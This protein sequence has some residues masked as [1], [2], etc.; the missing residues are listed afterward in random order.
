MV[1][2]GLL[3]S[4][5]SRSTYPINL[6]LLRCCTYVIDKTGIKSILFASCG[7]L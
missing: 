7:N 1:N 6:T 2:Y 5:N 3:W 4:Y